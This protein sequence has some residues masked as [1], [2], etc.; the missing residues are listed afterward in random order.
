MTLQN[1]NETI[2]AEHAVPWSW[3]FF[4]LQCSTD[5]PPEVLASQKLDWPQELLGPLPDNDWS[6]VYRGFH[7]TTP[8]GLRGIFAERRVKADLHG[9]RG[10]YATAVQDATPAS[11]P[12]LLAKFVH[13]P[14]K[15]DYGLCFELQYEG[16]SHISIQSGGVAREAELA[17]PEADRCT[18][19]RSGKES[20]WTFPGRYTQEKSLI[21]SPR[22][23]AGWHA[24]QHI[25]LP[26]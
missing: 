2:G 17:G 25:G 23:A 26:F 9:C 6:Y 7:G 3:R 20:R 5:E 22:R 1:L 18:H 10:V 24:R 21:V 14:S 8:S 16:H 4:F 11:L 12:P 15:F 13:H 19:L